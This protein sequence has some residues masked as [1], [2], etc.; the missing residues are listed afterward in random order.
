MRCSILLICCALLL[1]IT[2]QFT[3]AAQTSKATELNVF[4]AASLTEAF[5]AMA[6]EFEHAN[7][8]IKIILNFG[9]SQQ[10]VQQ[11]A[12][13]APIDLLA[14]ANMRQMLEGVKTGRLD[15]ASIIMFAR[16]RLVVVYPKENG[17]GIRSLRD[18]SNARLKIV[19]ADKAVPA[20][21]YALDVLAK[22]DRSNSFDASFSQKVLGNVVSYEENVKAVV[23]KI[24]LG[25]ADA[26]IVYAS[27]IS[28][29]V[30]EHAGV[31]EIPDSLNVIAEYPIA[32]ARDPSSR[33][34]A[35]KFLRYVLSDK[36][37]RVLTRFGFIPPQ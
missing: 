35:E 12:Q 20:G 21:Q 3:A 10:L 7:P 31:L 13:G 11:I 32:I 25:E 6:E 5:G 30:A 1:A 26:G 24:M 2:L 33:T 14:S 19:L 16:N 17:A 18:L 8:G 15:S 37:S 27:D 4:G 34:E 29:S 36:G 23:T 28:P 9:G 22:C